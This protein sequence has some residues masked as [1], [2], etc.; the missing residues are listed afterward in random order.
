M[1]LFC[2]CE[3]PELDAALAQLDADIQREAEAIDRE[4]AAEARWE[5]EHRFEPRGAFAP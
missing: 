4:E 3:L 1:T 2:G 5:D